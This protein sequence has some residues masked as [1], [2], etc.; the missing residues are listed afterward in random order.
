MFVPFD[1]LAVTNVVLAKEVDIAENR[2]G[3][4][5]VVTVANKALAFESVLG[6]GLDAM[7]RCTIGVVQLH[8]IRVGDRSTNGLESRSSVGARSR[9]VIRD[10][11]I[12]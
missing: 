9:V 12:S 3:I 1:C 4:E 6:V 10:T 8:C 11:V 5:G 7:N 2:A